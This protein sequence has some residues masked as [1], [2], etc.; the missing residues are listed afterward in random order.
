MKMT[1]TQLKELNP[2]EDGL[3]FVRSCRSLAVAWEKCERADWM[4]WLLRWLEKMPKEVSVTFARYCS[5]SAKKHAAA[6]ADNYASPV[7]AAA[8]AGYAANAANAANAADAAAA[9]ADTAYYAAANAAANAAAGYAA[10]ASADAEYAANAAADAHANE[11]K[12][13]ADFLRTLISNPFS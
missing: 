13:Q 8:A 7:A 12:K 6:A 1:V 9:Y 4:I 5:D 3:D 11:R 10:N 2:C